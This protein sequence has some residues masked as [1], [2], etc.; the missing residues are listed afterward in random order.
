M[1][2]KGRNGAGRGKGADHGAGAGH[3]TCDDIDNDDSILGRIVFNIEDI[4]LGQA[5]DIVV[6]DGDRIIVPKDSQTVTVI[7]EVYAPSTHFL[8]EQ[9][10][11]ADY[12]NASGGVNQ[13]GDLKAAYIIKGDGTVTPL[14]SVNSGFFRNSDNQLEGGDTIVVPIEIRTFSGVKL[15]N[16]VTQ[17]IYQVAVA[18]AAVNSF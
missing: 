14:S 16:E 3:G 8:R 12:V 17:V 13:F 11:F 18:T 10:S 9:S 7:G 15:A 2:R 5:K 4:F 6:R 1:V